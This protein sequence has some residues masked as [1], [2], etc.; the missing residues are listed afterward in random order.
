MAYITPSSQPPIPSPL[1]QPTLHLSPQVLTSNTLTQ[2]KFPT[3]TPTTTIQSATMTLPKYA[4]NYR[5][6]KRSELHKFI[7]ARCGPV[8]IKVRKTEKVYIDALR[9]MD[10]KAKFSRFMDLPAELR[11]MI[12]GHVLAPEP[13]K[14]TGYPIPTDGDPNLS[15][16]RVSKQVHAEAINVL[17]KHRTFHIDVRFRK[18]NA[19]REEFSRSAGIVYFPSTGQDDDD[20]HLS[21]RDDYFDKSMKALKNLPP[22]RSVEIKLS[23][24]TIGKRAEQRA[25]NKTMIMAREFLEAFVASKPDLRK[26]VIVLNFCDCPFDTVV[27]TMRPLRKLSERCTLDVTSFGEQLEEEVREMLAGNESGD[28]D[29]MQC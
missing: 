26:L 25:A 4:L 19:R 3:P 11:V 17:Y 5:V 20:L 18:R 23:L 12:Y 8:P 6:C 7:V 29:E 22:V 24:Y 10:K 21:P 28:V 16:L 27:D 13:K 2:I 1:I 9:E 15:I 14:S